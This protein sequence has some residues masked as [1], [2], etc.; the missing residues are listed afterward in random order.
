[1]YTRFGEEG[2]TLLVFTIYKSHTLCIKRAWSD[3]GGDFPKVQSKYWPQGI[4]IHVVLVL[5]TTHVLI[6]VQHEQGQL[7]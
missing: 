4:T 7:N 6:M 3:I 2:H 1:M 5:E